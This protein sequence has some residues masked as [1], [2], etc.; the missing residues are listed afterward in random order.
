MALFW[1][2][3]EE[4]IKQEKEEKLSEYN[5]DKYDSDGKYILNQIAEYEN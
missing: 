4:E 1:F 3:T 2:A 5:C